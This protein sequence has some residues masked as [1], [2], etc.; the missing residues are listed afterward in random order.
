MKRFES[1]PFKIGEKV[2]H[3][4]PGTKIQTVAFVGPGP[5]VGKAAGKDTIIHPPQT[6]VVKDM[7]GNLL[8]V[9]LADLKP[10]PAS[11]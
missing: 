5:R 10:L 2:L 8:I 1:G 3:C 6:A 11:E 4:P 7:D 9:N